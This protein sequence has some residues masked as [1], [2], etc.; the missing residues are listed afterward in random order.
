MSIRFIEESLSSIISRKPTGP[1]LL[2]VVGAGLGAGKNFGI[3]NVEISWKLQTKTESICESSLSTHV[4]RTTI[5]VWS[6]TI[7]MIRRLK[8]TI[9]QNSVISTHILWLTT[10]CRLFLPEVRMIPYGW[11]LWVI[12]THPLALV[13]Q[14]RPEERSGWINGLQE[15]L[16]RSVFLA[17]LTIA[18]GHIIWQGCCKLVFSLMAILSSIESIRSFKRGVELFANKISE[19]AWRQLTLAF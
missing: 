13:S 16:K 10:I 15:S 4:R 1:S 5:G 11:F 12:L 8:F 9:A 19:K 7:E 3:K 2:S 17:L 6:I 18:G 14:L